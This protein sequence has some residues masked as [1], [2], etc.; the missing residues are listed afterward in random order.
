[1]GYR[2]VYGD[3]P[4]VGRKGHVSLWTAL[5]L[6]VFVTVVRLTWPVGTESLRGVLV[7]EEQTMQAFAQMVES[8]GNGQG[9][10][11]AVTVFCQTV[12]AHGLAE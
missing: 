6:L 8:V 11:E 3:E 1:M 10:G 9:M 12:V 5:F 4:G 7:P 2:I